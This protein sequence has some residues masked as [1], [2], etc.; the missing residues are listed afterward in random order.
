MEEGRK[1]GRM[2]G[3]VRT[4]H[5]A[6]VAVGSAPAASTT[7]EGR[8]GRRKDGVHR[9]ST[10]GGPHRSRP[11]Y[12]RRGRDRS[13]R[14]ASRIATDPVLAKVRSA[15]VLV[16]LGTPAVVPRRFL[17]SAAPPHSWSPR[18]VASSQRTPKHLGSTLPRPDGPRRHECGTIHET[19][20]SGPCACDSPPPS[21]RQRRAGGSCTSDERS[22][23]ADRA[24]GRAERAVSGAHRLSP[25]ARRRR[26]AG[27]SAAGR[28]PTADRQHKHRGREARTAARGLSAAHSGLRVPE[29]LRGARRRAAIVSAALATTRAVD[30]GARPASTPHP[31]SVAGRGVSV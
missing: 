21:P 22:D 12:H 18:R 25:G 11:L 5:C 28:D 24:R 3:E 29:S 14:V 17:T 23:R 6:S 16:L 2:S 20:P 30:R 19:A 8:R 4:S 9:C 1:M 10:C 26:S 15:R 31:C 7:L 13:S 27:C